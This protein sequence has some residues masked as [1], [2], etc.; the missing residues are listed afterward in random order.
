[1]GSNPVIPS[2]PKSTEPKTKAC[3]NRPSCPVSPPS[4]QSEQNSN[5]EFIPPATPQPTNIPQPKTPI[6]DVPTKI[7]TSKTSTLLRSSMQPSTVPHRT[8]EPPLKP[9]SPL[10][11]VPPLSSPILSPP[12]NTNA[13]STK[14]TRKRKRQE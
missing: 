6:P 1:M 8:I 10:D 12:K 7:Q 2:K 3:A 9:S 5:S 4:S 11:S 14:E 13:P